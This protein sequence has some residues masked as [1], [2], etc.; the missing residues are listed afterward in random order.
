MIDEYIVTSSSY[1]AAGS[2][3]FGYIDGVLFSNSFS[4][5]EY[6]E[7]TANGIF[8]VTSWRRL[9]TRYLYERFHRV[10]HCQPME[11]MAGI[12]AME[13]YGAV[14][15]VELLFIRKNV[16]ISQSWPKKSGII[17]SA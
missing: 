4:I 6:I 2:G 12:G 9:F 14:F 1:A 17:H 10:Y 5:A 8:P 15:A 7:L 13:S 3:A 16:G 11:V